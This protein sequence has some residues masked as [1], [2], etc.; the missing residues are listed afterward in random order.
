M[1]PGGAVDSPCAILKLSSFNAIRVVPIF[2]FISIARILIKNISL[3]SL[4]PTG[5]F[6]FI[7]ALVHRSENQF[8]IR[9]GR[10]SRARISSLEFLISW[11]TT[12]NA[13]W[14]PYWWMYFWMSPVR[15]LSM[16]IY[17]A[18][19]AA[20]YKIATTFLSFPQYF[21]RGIARTLCMIATHQLWSPSHD[22]TSAPRTDKYL[23]RSPVVMASHRMKY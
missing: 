16:F 8:A 13:C 19:T 4:K 10:T 2:L 15:D 9:D 14:K 17:C 5:G 22:V 12:R 18:V 21:P 1:L 20:R 7:S 11:F 23:R 3:L 6:F